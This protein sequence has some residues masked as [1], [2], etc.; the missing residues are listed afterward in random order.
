MTH[1]RP[2]L[3]VD[4]ALITVSDGALQCLML[5]R[6]DADRVG[7]DWALPGGY[8]RIDETV[9]AAALR[10]LRDK[11]GIASAYLEQLYTYG[12]LDR[13]PRERVVSVTYLALIPE[14]ALS[15]AIAGSDALQLASIRTDWTGEAG[16]PATA[17]QEDGA[18]LKLAFDH[19]DLL[20]DVVKRLR[21]KLDYTDIALEL[22]P[23]QFTLRA[24]QEVYEAILGRPLAKPAFRR[25]LLDRNTI[26]ATGKR[27]QASAFRPAE[28]YTRL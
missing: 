27:E 18:R 17:S 26:Q 7:G 16:G 8:V 11:A 1:P 24:A 23:E 10:V 9:D 6:D 25:K 2:A 12:A 19:A 4:L 15:G 20:G 13:D 5:Q 28:L 22:L 21:G 3:A 14:D